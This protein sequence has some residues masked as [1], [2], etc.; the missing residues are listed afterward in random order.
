[1]DRVFTLAGQGTVVTGTALAGSVRVGDTLQLAPG[2][3]RCACAAST[4]RTVRRSGA[5]ASAAR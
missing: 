3:S 4:P 1:V 2:G 5:P